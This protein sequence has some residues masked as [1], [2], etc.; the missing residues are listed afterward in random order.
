[1]TKKKLGKIA[2]TTG[3]FSLVLAIAL[4]LSAGGILAANLYANAPGLGAAHSFAVLAATSA[5]SANTT[6][7]WG[8]LGLSPGLE[9]SR[10]GPWVVN[11][12]EYFGTG[13]LSEDA[14]A[15]AL[16]AYNN[17]AGQGSDGLWN[18]EPNPV[19]GVWEA[20]DSP[21]FSGTLTLTGDY[22]D[23]WVFQI[24]DSLTFTGNV[25][26][27]GDAQA[28]NVFWQVSVDATIASGSNFVGT[29]IAGRDITLVSGASVSGRVISFRD[30]TVD[31][32]TI[33]YPPCQTSPADPTPTTGPADPT[34][35]TGPADPTPTTAPPAA[36]PEPGQLPGTGGDLAGP[37]SQ[38][39]PITL[40]AL[41][42]V[43]I[44]FGFMLIRNNRK[45]IR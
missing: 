43:L 30:I 6:T 18:L 42:F 16:G 44:L 24:S 12:D 23:V 14:M 32:N 33:T 27:G 28:C 4:S 21:S 36:T 37:G 26:M 10:T 19:P 45:A 13:G 41:S 35:T 2:Y 29:L 9:V 22:D 11:G 15:G 38:L 31:A 5:A 40:G 34:P 8:D 1:M 7:I 25:V 3:L 20:A 39:I 17:L